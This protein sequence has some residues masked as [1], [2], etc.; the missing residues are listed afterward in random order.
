MFTGGLH[1]TYMAYSILLVIYSSLQDSY[2]VYKWLTCD[3]H[4]IYSS[5]QD[6][7]MFTGGLHVTYIV[8]TEL[9]CKSV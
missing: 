4:G 1:V 7:T 3:L 5:L 9:Q 8:Y 6:L 2:N